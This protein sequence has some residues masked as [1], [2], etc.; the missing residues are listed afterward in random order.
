MQ[1]LPYL[2]WKQ[3]TTQHYWSLH[4]AI[5]SMQYVFRAHVMIVL[6]CIRRARH[7][8]CYRSTAHKGVPHEAFRATHAIM[9]RCGQCRASQLRAC[10]RPPISAGGAL[11]VCIPRGCREAPPKT[12]QA[13]PGKSDDQMYRPHEESLCDARNKAF[14]S[15]TARNPSRPQNLPRTSCRS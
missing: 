6:T 12:T 11:S 10:L 3:Q 13:R 1:V 7:G 5:H 15:T 4:T 14:R 2:I 9:Y 8:R